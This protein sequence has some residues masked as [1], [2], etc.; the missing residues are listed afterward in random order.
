[1]FF[2]ENCAIR[3]YIDAKNTVFI[4]FF[5][6]FFDFLSEIAQNWAILFNFDTKMTKTNLTAYT[7]LRNLFL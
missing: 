3:A 4:P 6:E 5:N 1:M 2:E 7:A